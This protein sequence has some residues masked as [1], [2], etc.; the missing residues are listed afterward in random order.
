MFIFTLGKK[1]ERDFCQRNVLEELQTLVYPVITVISTL[2][3]SP[4]SFTLR[5]FS[6][7]SSGIRLHL[8]PDKQPSITCWCPPEIRRSGL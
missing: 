6:I 8:S 7:A 4:L 5:L 1:K 3:P 2:A